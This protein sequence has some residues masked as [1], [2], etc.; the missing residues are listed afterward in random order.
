MRTAYGLIALFIAT[1]HGVPVEA[2]VSIAHVSVP[3]QGLTG[4][5]MMFVL[6]VTNEGPQ[7]ATSV[8]IFD[9]LPTWSSFVWVTA[10]CTY[11]FEPATISD[12]NGPPGTT[13]V[14]CELGSIEAGSSRFVKVVARPTAGGP[15]RNVASVY[16]SES[17]PDIADNTSEAFVPVSAS[18]VANLVSRYRLYNDVSK[19]HH[20]TTDLNEYNMLGAQTAV[21]TQ[22]GTAG[23]VLDNP[24]AFNGVT[25]VPYYRMQNRQTGVHHWTTDPNEYY[26]L[27]E[28]APWNGEGVDGFIL[29]TQAPGSIPLYRLMYPFIAGLHHWTIDTNEYDTLTGQHGWIGEGGSGFVIQ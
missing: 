4:R 23:R 13:Y 16:L 5:D 26:T 11:T 8:R 9:R 21:W 15:A 18:P 10:G 17:E 27:A 2:N 3:S 20:F 19:E 22:E 28:V 1:L 24:G 29:P 25:A 14:T 6:R 7:T 12:P